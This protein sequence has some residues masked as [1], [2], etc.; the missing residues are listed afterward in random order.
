MWLGASID[1]LF[2][3]ALPGI[4]NSLADGRIG[5]PRGHGFALDHGLLH[6]LIKRNLPD[7]REIV[8]LTIG[9]KLLHPLRVEVGFV[10]AD[11][12]GHSKV[13]GGLADALQVVL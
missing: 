8:L 3:H 7:N 12:R 9:P 2:D 11:Q 10:D 13:G 1:R 6:V 4:H 5:A